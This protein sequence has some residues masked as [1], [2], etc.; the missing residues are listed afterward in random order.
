MSRKLMKRTFRISFISCIAGLALP[1]FAAE[2]PI[3]DVGT[4]D[5]TSA[6]QAFPERPPYSPYAGSNFPM[7]PFFGDTHVHTSFSMD[8]GAFGCRLSPRDAYRFARGEQVIASS[9][10]PAKLS[11]PLD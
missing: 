7:R 2:Q 1:A 4:L 10:Q 3:T 5:E 9:G 6:K 11:R 8:A